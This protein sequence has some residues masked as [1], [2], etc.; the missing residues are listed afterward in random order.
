MSDSSTSETPERAIP[1][2]VNGKRFTTG[3]IA[4]LRPGLDDSA[5]PAP[6]TNERSVHQ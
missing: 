2:T 3:Q 6:Q 5:T 4:V 1:F